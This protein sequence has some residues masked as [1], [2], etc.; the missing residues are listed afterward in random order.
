MN[1]ILENSLTEKSNSIL[2]DFEFASGSAIGREHLYVGNAP[3][4]ALIGK[5]NQ[6]A[7]CSIC[8]SNF[9]VAI[10][11]DGCSEGLYNEIGAKIG[12]NFITK[13]IATRLRAFSGEESLSI[14]IALE[15]TRLNVL[16]Q[17][18]LLLNAFPGSFK[19]NVD[20]YM[21]FSVMGLIMT[22]N[23]L[24]VFSIGD[25]YY[26]I[27]DVLF[28]IG[29]FPNNMPPY[30]SY[31]LVEKQMVKDNPDIVKFTIHETLD[32]KRVQSVMISTDGLEYIRKN[33]DTLVPGTKQLVGPISQFWQNDDFY[34][35]PFALSRRL[36]RM[37]Y[38]A[39]TVVDGRIREVSGLLKDDTTLMVLR[40]KPIVEG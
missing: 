11:T 16:A 27:N 20:N 38:D 9:I 28:R 31:D 14:S 23:F 24:V 19:S 17:L 6:D 4:K 35:N 33:E 26:A 10:V 18:R 21:L 30:M 2:T 12:A 37:N 40:R 15:Y 7:Y 13:E 1:L 22:K 25:G 36:M 32:I 8:D 5:S 3:A 34:K 29:P 39:Q